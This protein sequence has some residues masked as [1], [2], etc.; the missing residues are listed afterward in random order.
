MDL[1]AA[2]RRLETA[3]TEQTE[4]PC[5]HGIRPPVFGVS[6]AELG[7]LRKEIGVDH[8]LA[9]ALWATGNHDARILTT[10]VANPERIV[11][12]EADGRRARAGS[13]RRSSR[14][15]ASSPTPSATPCCGGSDARSTGVRTVSGTR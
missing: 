7:K 13:S 8:S 12:R 10:K 2:M 9:R 4:G 5:R 14:S 11:A 1:K 3:G 6:Y 15:E